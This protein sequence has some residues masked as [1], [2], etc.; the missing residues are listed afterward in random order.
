MAHTFEVVEAKEHQVGQIVR[1]LR[2]GHTAA[3]ARLGYDRRETHRQLSMLY[4]QSS[5]RRAWIVD[6]KLAALGGV[7]GMLLSDTGF[8]W[9]ALS[10]EVLKF[11]VAMI[12]EARK[13]IAEMMA[14]RREL[15]T[16]IIGSDDV[17]LRFVRFLGF[18][19]D[20]KIPVGTGHAIAVGYHT[21]GHD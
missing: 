1:K 10:D 17:A 7:T 20:H 13:Q 16:T 18:H 12:K 3:L 11:R 21:G 2:L 5:F 9:L 4:R 8:I 6:G 15:A 19:G 14:T